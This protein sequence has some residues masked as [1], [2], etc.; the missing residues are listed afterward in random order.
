MNNDTINKLFFS[1]APLTN[2]LRQP[3]CSLTNP[4]SLVLL[5]TP[6][7]QCSVLYACVLSVLVLNKSEINVFDSEPD[8]APPP[9]S[10][11]PRM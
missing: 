10:V 4:H 3:P 2:Q 1:E 9:L 11:T 7:P 5:S 8:V 6:F